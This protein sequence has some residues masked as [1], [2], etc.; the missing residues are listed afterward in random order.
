MAKHKKG[1]QVLKHEQKT[2]EKRKKIAERNRMKG[3]K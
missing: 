2:K 1:R 3:S